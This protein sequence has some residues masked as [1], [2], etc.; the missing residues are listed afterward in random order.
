MQ[1]RKTARVTPDEYEHNHVHIH[2]QKMYMQLPYKFKG[3]VAMFN[4][5]QEN[6]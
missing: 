6:I 5:V 4:K 3:L 1:T 2:T